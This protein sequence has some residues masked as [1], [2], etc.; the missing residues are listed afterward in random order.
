M[1]LQILA[2][3]LAQ[4]FSTDKEAL[5]GKIDQLMELEETQIMAF[6]QMEKKRDKLK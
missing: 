4:K 2:L 3:Q 5:Q 6:N 1:N